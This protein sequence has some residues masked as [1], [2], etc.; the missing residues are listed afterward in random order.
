MTRPAPADFDLDLDLALVDRIEGRIGLAV[1]G[2][3]DS[4]ALAVLLCEARPTREFVLLT[5]DHGLRPEAARECRFVEQVAAGLGRPAAVLPIS[6][7]RQGSLQAWARDARYDRLSEAACEHGLAAIATGHTLDDQA[8]T[9]MLRLARGSGLKGLAS[10]RP[11]TVHHGVRIVRP[12]LR[13]RRGRLQRALGRRGITWCE[14]PSNTDTRFDRAAMRRLLPQF[15]AMGLTP[16]RLAG[17]ATHLRRASDLVDGLTEELL[18]SGLRLERTGAVVLEAER[19]R[20]AH[21]EVRLRA[22]GEAVQMA[23]GLPHPPRFETLA[24]AEAALRRG[25][26]ASLGRANA[27]PRCGTIQFWRETRG[28]RAVT[29]APGGRA[30]FDGRYCVTVPPGGCAVRVEPAG[31]AARPFLR[32]GE[33]RG[34]AATAPAVIAAADG[35]LVALPT[36]GVR[37]RGWPAD[38]V[39][40]TLW[41]PGARFGPKG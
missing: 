27:V 24:A 25:E 29:V 32:A 26:R 12:L 1:S 19:W 36:F 4:V 35:E 39:S 5:V 15:A 23:G 17:T 8:E 40:V 37:R 6:Q 22:L 10:M 31:Q 16:E 34:A 20:G 38:G 21:E 14:D 13:E 18:R 28:V 3:S 30:I 7:P 11:D 33:V 9:L 2:G 41:R